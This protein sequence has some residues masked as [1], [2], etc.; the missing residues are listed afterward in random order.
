M[1]QPEQTFGGLIKNARQEQGFSQRELAKIIDINFTYLSK[2]EN[3]RV[4]YPPS[5]AAIRAIAKTLDL[6]EEELIFLAG[7]LPECNFPLLKENYQ[8]MAVLFRRMRDIPGF[9]EKVFDL[10]S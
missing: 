8:E 1:N 4:L 9:T 2:L 10:C 6:N 3:N 7:R 5:E